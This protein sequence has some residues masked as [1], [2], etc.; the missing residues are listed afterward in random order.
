[1]QSQVVARHLSG[2]ETVNLCS[3]CHALWFDA[4]ESVRLTPGA[5]L[6]L[7]DAIRNA[8]PAGR[9]ALPARL[10]CPRCKEPLV[11]TQDLQRTTRFSYYRCPHGHGRFTPFFQF[12]REKNFVRAPAPAELARLKAAI[13]VIRCSSCG[14][15]VDL[16]KDAACPYCRTPI[17]ILDPDAVAATI[18]ALETAET[19]RRTMYVD[20]MVGGM[21]DAHQRLHAGDGSSSAGRDDT[22]AADLVDLG[23]AVLT[24]L[25]AR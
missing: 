4:L 13:R 22:Q 9:R 3:T 5:T 1:M 21:V 20:A 12:L 2:Q 24:R 23:L 7:F 19:K 15:P 16:E 8:A 17:T 6:E 18:H 10:P 14:A 25:L 11:L